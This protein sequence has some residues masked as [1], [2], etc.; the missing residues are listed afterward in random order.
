M[1]F[2]EGQKYRHRKHPFTSVTLGCRQTTPY[3]N[4]ATG[5]KTEN[6]LHIFHD[7]HNIKKR[8]RI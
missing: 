2:D 5:V 8:Q 1:H 4:A 6:L 7:K 3:S